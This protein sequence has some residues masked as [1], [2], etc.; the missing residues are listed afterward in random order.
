[1]IISI[2]ILITGC[3]FQAFISWNIH[4]Q[5]PRATTNIYEQQYQMASFLKRFYDNDRVAL[6]DIGTSN[7][8]TDIMCTDLW[9]L[10]DLEISRLRR[11]HSI[12]ENDIDRI[13]KAKKVSISI[14][15][16]SWFREDDSSII[17]VTWY[18]AGEWVIQNNVIAGDSV[19][20]FY[21][22]NPQKKAELI[23]N[24]RSFSGFLPRSVIQRG[25]YLNR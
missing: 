13:T 8:F 19:I 25:N 24:L 11:N 23:D 14:L 9:G 18:K 17:P 1:V 16:D 21:A 4:V 12:S 6:N 10:S 3:I 15:Y 20:S 2:L 22:V 7:Y 5:T